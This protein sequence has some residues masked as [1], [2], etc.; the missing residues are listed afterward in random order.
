MNNAEFFAAIKMLAKEKGITPESLCEGIQRAIVTVVKKDMNGKDIVF[1]EIDYEKQKIKIFLRKNVVEVIEDPDTDILP[2]E[3]KAYDPDAEAGGTVDIPFDTDT[4]SRIAAEKGKHVLRQGIGEAEKESR[5]QK[6][7]SK[8]QEIVTARILKIDSRT[9]NAIIEFDGIEETLPKSEQLPGEFLREGE[10]VKVF[11]AD[12]KGVDGKVSKA[13]VSRTHPGLVKR[14]F[15]TEVPE[16]FEG[17]VEI[18]AVSREAGSRTKIAV[19]SNEENVEPVGACIGPRGARVNKIV[20]LLGGEKIDIIRYSEVPEDFIAEALKPADVIKVELSETGEKS[21]TVTVPE[22]Q[23]SLAIGNKGQNVRLAA[24]LTGYKIDI[25][26]DT[27]RQQETSS[28]D[29][30]IKF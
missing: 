27:T 25:K 28:F 30:S 29:Y 20:D 14:L 26:A 8:K 17:S 10:L 19:I 6:L 18:K 9:G 24:K 7:L 23:L 4:F 2:A 16:I 21:C 15:E 13:T 12:L 22:N 11:I 1:C 5:S 3:A